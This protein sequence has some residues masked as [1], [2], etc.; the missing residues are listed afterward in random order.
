MYAKDLGKLQSI[1]VSATRCLDCR[2]PRCVNTCP[3]HVD[4]QAAMRLIVA[5]ADERGAA[6]TQ[7]PDQAA[8][9]AADGVQAS[10]EP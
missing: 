3:E 5:R 7:R 1:L 8:S 10:F 9:S 2:D 4:V 6:W